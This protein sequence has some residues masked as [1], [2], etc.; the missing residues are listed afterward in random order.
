MSTPPRGIVVSPFAK[1]SIGGYFHEEKGAVYWG[2]RYDQ[3][4]D[5]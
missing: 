3:H 2:D 5:R 1:K 4:R